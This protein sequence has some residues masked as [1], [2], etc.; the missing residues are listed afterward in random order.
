M[1]RYGFA[2]TIAF[3]VIAQFALMLGFASG[4]ELR[5]FADDSVSYLV[6]ARYLS[7]WTSADAATVAAWPHEIYPPLFPL[8][9]AVVDAGNHLDRAHLVTVASYSV[10]LVLLAV[11]ARRIT[12]SARVASATVLL[13]AVSYYA[14]L[15]NLR[16]LS[17][18][19][20]MALVILALLVLDWAAARP[21]RHLVVGLI[22]GLVVLTRSIGFALLLAYVL[23]MVFAMGR[24]EESP[25]GLLAG[26]AVACATIIPWYVVRPEQA[27]SR[28][29]QGLDW[30]LNAVEEGGLVRLLSPQ[31]EVLDE[32]WIGL[33]TP[34]LLPGF[35]LQDLV[36][37]LVVVFA[38]VGLVQG[39]VR[40]RVHAW[41]VVI[42][43]GVLLVWPYPGQMTRF[44]LC[45]APLV[46]VL[47]AQAVQAGAVRVVPGRAKLLAAAVPLSLA[48][49]LALPAMGSIHGRLQF[50]DTRQDYARIAE[51]YITPDPK[52]AR[53]RAEVQLLMFDELRW[54]GAN[55]PPD[56]RVM[57]LVP[58][59]TAYLA[60]REAISF[61]HHLGGLELARA[62]KASGADYVWLS[63]LHPRFTREDVDGTAMAA[64]LRGLATVVRARN[65]QLDGRPVAVLLRVDDAALDRALVRAPG[66][67][68]ATN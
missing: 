22:L 2:L 47:A 21:R 30:A 39:L 14:W 11:W 44:F 32:A 31:L 5:S 45:L 12:G 49:V 19:L 16:I 29:G 62:L 65:S 35:G 54:L 18:G 3:I 57:A 58:A 23:H 33:W 38:L 50:N 55:L 59:Y 66:I 41:Y 46:L 27:A 9:L 64:R 34:Y 15:H 10:F 67:S 42:S 7:P 4:G 43:M 48:L 52:V 53:Q 28:Y 20:F 63:R 26:L 24:R 13:M 40:T 37:I 68:S 17:E 8:L 60:R 1:T 51:F 61:P 6:M 36:L 25:R 56:A